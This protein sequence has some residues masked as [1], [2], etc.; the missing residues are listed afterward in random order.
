MRRCCVFVCLV[1]LLGACESDDSA[2]PNAIGGAASGASAGSS[3]S[4]V[5]GS[6]AGSGGSAQG[7]QGHGAS[8]GQAGSAGVAGV[9]GTSGTGGSAMAGNAGT[10]ASG[11]AGT[12]GSGGV[13]GTG[14]NAGGSGS[15]GVGATGGL[16]GTAG[17]GGSVTNSLEIVLQDLR[18]NRDFALL[19]YSSQG[20]PLKVEGG[21]LFVSTD[22]SLNLTAGDHDAW[23]GTPM[24]VEQT[25]AWVVID[26]VDGDKYK[27]TDGV[28]Y[29]PD[30]WS[31]A[32]QYDQFGEISLVKPHTAHLDRYFGIADI[33]VAPRTVRVWVPDVAPT[34]VLYVHDGQNLFDPNAIWGGWHLQDS[35]PPAMM[36]VGIDNTPDRMDEYTHVPDDIGSGS[37]IGG[38]GDQYADFLKQ[39]VRPII[40]A[41]YGEPPILGVMGSSLG[42]L[43]SF[44]IA[45]RHP[46]EYAFAASL[47]GTMGWGSIGASIHNETMIE[48]YQT[49]GHQNTVL[50][51]DSGGN[52]GPC[53]DADND[54]IMDDSDA[55]D[56]YCENEQLKNVLQGVGYVIDQDL[57][58]VWDPAAEHNEAAW[59]ARVSG[60]LTIF[61]NL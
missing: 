5:G 47:S 19:D 44:H 8:A 48:R 22:I 3:G 55:G 32:Y 29:M 23:A 59:A 18:D 1:G 15:A 25:F 10:G 38:L 57:F 45:D 28:T 20:W 60:P 43:I 52:N 35:V 9:S 37:F 21:Y 53:S 17:A 14:G 46:N 24:T 50:Y 31:R 7:G 12:S 33:N 26:V 13:S 40:Q 39:T 2:A 30:I 49:H 4:G 51:L 6:N 41:E 36:L 42:G 54:G 16:A 11:T 58:Y 56:N 61:D 34:R 27:F